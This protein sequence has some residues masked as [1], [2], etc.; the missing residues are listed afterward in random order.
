MTVITGTYMY[1]I[2]CLDHFQRWSKYLHLITTSLSVDDGRGRGPPCSGG[3]DD[4]AAGCGC[5]HTATITAD[6]AVWRERGGI[7]RQDFL[8]ARE[9]RF[10]GVHYQII[11]HVLYREPDCM[12]GPRWDVCAS[13]DTLHVKLPYATICNFLK[14]AIVL[15]RHNFPACI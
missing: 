11:D 8:S 14:M 7:T 12:F 10:R 6:L 13:V 2:L 5:P 3:G 9:E 1:I 15:G 4:S